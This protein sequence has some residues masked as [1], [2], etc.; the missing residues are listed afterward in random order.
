MRGGNKNPIFRLASPIAI[1]I[2]YHTTPKNKHPVD[3]KIPTH[4]ENRIQTINH[5]SR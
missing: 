3:L 5:T 1:P 4:Y 2:V